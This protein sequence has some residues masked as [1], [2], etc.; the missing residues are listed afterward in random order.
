MRDFSVPGSDPPQAEALLVSSSPMAAGSGTIWTRAREGVQRALRFIQRDLWLSLP[1]D[2]R[3]RFFYRLLRLAVLIVEGFSRSEVFLL[4][5]ALTYQVIFALVPLL[6]VTLAIVKGFGGMEGLGQEVQKFLMKYFIPEVSAAKVDSIVNSVNIAA[7]GAVGFVVLLYTSLSFL[8]TIERAFN[9][10][11]GVHTGRPLLRRFTLYWTLLTVTPVL[12]AASISLA[13]LAR[14]HSIY[15]WISSHVPFF[16]QLVVF[17]TQY[18][19]AWILFTG[20]YLFM[21]NTKVRL[22][23]AVTGALVSGTVWQLM[24]NAYVWYNT[25]VVSVEKFY[26]SL[27]AIPVFLLW[28]YLGWIIVL[29]GAEVAFAVQHVNTYRREVE[30]VRLSASARERLALASA[31]EVVRPFLSGGEPPTGEQIAARLNSPVRAVN[32]ILFELA[33]RGILRSVPAAGRKDPVYL[34][35]RDPLTMTARDVVAAVRDHGDAAPLPDEP[36][37]Q[38]VIELIDRSERQA[39]G[40]LETATLRDLAGAPPPKASS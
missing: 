34:P 10:I 7:A 40:P 23:A 12:L 21:P 22:G 28:V 36:G 5:A 16:T 32:D 15:A 1:E 33:T 31:L 14:S 27:G 17:T 3:T 11:W 35:T 39:Y 30:E 6:V 37:I 20:I 13:T 2:R 38:V 19:V 4:A 8:G 29:F 18:L 24:M 26:G 25:H 9:K